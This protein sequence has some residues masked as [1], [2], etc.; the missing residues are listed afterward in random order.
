MDKFYRHVI[1]EALEYPHLLSE[2]ETEFIDSIA[3]RD[4]DYELSDKQKH[5]LNKIS[6]KVALER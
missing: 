2:W 1:K 6:S 3:E 5:V 4:D